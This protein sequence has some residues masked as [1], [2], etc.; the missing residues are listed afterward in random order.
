MTNKLHELLTERYA[1]QTPPLSDSAETLL[2]PT[3]ST[4]FQHKS[5]RQFLDKPVTD[6]QLT[7]IVA[8]AQSASTSSSLQSWSLI[9]V[10]DPEKRARIA[11]TCGNSGA[12]VNAA[13]VFLV[14][15]IDYA[16]AADLLEAAG[17]TG[18]TLDLFETTAVG[19]VDVGI[20][21]QNALVAAESMGLGGVYAGSLRNNVPN[22]VETLGLPQHVFP[23]VG[24]ALGH[25][26]PA[27]GTSV[28]PRL[29]QSVV[30]HSDGYNAEQWRSGVEAYD[31]DYGAYYAAQGHADAQW[32]RVLVNRLRDP[33]LLG[34]RQHLRS[35]LNSQG[36][37]SN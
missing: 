1:S 8:A 29:P 36:F 18:H 15:V 17:E 22:V 3:L 26:D 10:R 30:V 21:S 19:L 23:V 27:E 31:R 35:H 25:P 11:E 9:V 2:N 13:P 14:W 5:V 16:R 32:S 4:M 34:G 12:F 6:D 33:G 24:L 37:P 28:K 20:A 7:L